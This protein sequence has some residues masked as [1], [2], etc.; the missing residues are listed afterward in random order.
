MLWRRM[1]RK[2]EEKKKGSSQ[3]EC[4]NRCVTAAGRRP[5]RPRRHTLPHFIGGVCAFIVLLKLILLAAPQ[6]GDGPFARFL[7]SLR[8]CS[9]RFLEQ[10]AVLPDIGSLAFISFSLV[11]VCRQIHP[12]DSTVC[13]HLCCR[14]S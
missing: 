4:R 14:R 8:L 10:T 11:L 7:L 3:N 12:T 13:A 2:V 5:R 9:R 1:W 6:I